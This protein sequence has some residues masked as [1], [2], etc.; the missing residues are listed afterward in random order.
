MYAL[1][2]CYLDPN[3]N[4]PKV[5]DFFGV[6]TNKNKI[7]GKLRN[8]STV[9][10]F[11]GYSVDH[12]HNVYC[13]LNLGTNCVIDSRDIEWLKL[14]HKI[15]INKSNQV[16]RIANNDNDDNVIEPLMIREV[17]NGSESNINS[18]QPKVKDTSYLKIY[19]QMKRLESSFNPEA[20]KIID[21]FVHG[22]EILLDSVN[23]A[24]I[25]GNVVKAPQSFDDA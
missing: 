14:Y 20:S 4:Y 2:N 5:L 21:N 19:C 7:Q 15:W 25:C 23:L 11:V 17:N 12:A 13:M 8:R 1:I 10:I 22:R 16:E 18:T 3:Q 9:C 24:L 6:V